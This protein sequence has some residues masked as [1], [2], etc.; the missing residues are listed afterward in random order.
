MCRRWR[1]VYDGFRPVFSELVWVLGFLCYVGCY[2]EGGVSRGGV[3][4]GGSVR[5]WWAEECLRILVDLT[6]Q[7]IQH[8]KSLG[9]QCSW[10]LRRA[11]R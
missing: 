6:D 5:P 1:T 10:R 11:Q 2:D 8:Q 7:E 9:T 4:F 3:G